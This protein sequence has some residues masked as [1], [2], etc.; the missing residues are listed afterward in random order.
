M[1]FRSSVSRSAIKSLSSLAGGVSGFVKAAGPVAAVAGTFLLAAEALERLDK[2]AGNLPTRNVFENLNLKDSV[3]QGMTPKPQGG[4]AL[5]LNLFSKKDNSPDYVKGLG[6]E[7]TKTKKDINSL[8]TSMEGLFDSTSK[9]N[10]ETK[11][12]ADLF[13]Q[14]QKDIKDA[15]QKSLV[16]TDTF[17]VGTEKSEIYQKAISDLIEMGVSPYHMVIQKLKEAMDALQQSTIAQLEPLALFQEAT[18]AAKNKIYNISDAVNQSNENIQQFVSKQKDSGLTLEE[19][20]GMA[21]DVLL[22]MTDSLAAI[23][24]SGKSAFQAL[25]AAAVD[26]AKGLIRAGLAAL[27][28]SVF[29]NIPFPAS[30]IVAGGAIAA[31]AALTALLPK[32]AKGAVVSGP[33]ALM[34]GDNPNASVDPEVISPLSKLKELMGEGT[35]RIHVTGQLV[36]HGNQIIGVI[37]SAYTTRSGLRGY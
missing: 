15:E 9:Q 26:A 31:G 11:K 19:F 33:T 25:K 16:F 12:M 37:D 10:K 21:N 13:K 32:A 4:S 23:A 5:G 36:G 6:T 8:I 17:Q 35:R 7:A 2:A 22:G 27:L 24:T 3:R 18:E 28:E 20:G 30:L 14:L 34:V 1:L 29:T